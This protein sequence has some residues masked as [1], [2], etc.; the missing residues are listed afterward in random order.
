MIL[1]HLA[2]AQQVAQDK[3]GTESANDYTIFN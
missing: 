2:E 1:L 3:D